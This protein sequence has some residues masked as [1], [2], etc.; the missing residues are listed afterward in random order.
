MLTGA[1]THRFQNLNLLSP[2]ELATLDRWELERRAR[3]LA[4]TAYLGQSTALCRS[5]GRYKMFID[6]ADVGFGAHL[7]L[8]G[9]WEPWLTVFMARRLSSGMHVADV[10]ANHGYYT[11]LMADLAGP[12]GRVAAIE[13]NPRIADLLRRSV[14]VN[15]FSDRVQVHE[16]AATG[17]DDQTVWLRLP[18]HEPKNSHL[19]AG[20]G[21]AANPGDVIVQAKGGRLSTALAEWPRLDFAKIDVEGAEESAVEGLF[22]VLQRDRP[23]MVLEFN[24]HRCA[25]PRDLVDR[26]ESLYGVIRHVDFDA[27]AHATDKEALFDPAHQEDWLLFLSK[28]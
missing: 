22:P 19:V 20:P 23:D 16:M 24:A 4:R 9:F 7:L 17:E 13:P 21:A 3:G 11:L 6:T 27:E 12:Q 10:G 2:N 26:L 28:T 1:R 25:K 15:G 8:D 5:L 18:A 14:A